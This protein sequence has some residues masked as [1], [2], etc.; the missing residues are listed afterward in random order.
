MEFVQ[1]LQGTE[2]EEFAHKVLY[3]K[4]ASYQ[5]V[6][7]A[8]GGDRGIDGFNGDGVVFQCYGPDPSITIAERAKRHKG[9]LN[10]DLTTFIDRLDAIATLVGAQ[11]ARWVLFVPKCDSAAVLEAAAEHQA[12][13]RSLGRPELHPEFEVRIQ[14]AG[15][16][17]PQVR[18][19]LQG[20]SEL[21]FGLHVG[22]QTVELEVPNEW[23]E[24]LERKVRILGPQQP[25]EFAQMLLD[26][27]ARAT[28]ATRD[29]ED[30]WPE[31]FQIYK[32]VR[33]GQ[34]N[35]VQVASQVS[36]GQDP[37]AFIAE[38]A[39]QA[40]TAAREAIPQLSQPLCDELGWGFIAEMLM[41]CTVDFVDET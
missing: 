20:V 30:G 39:A 18:M 22:T 41:E 27:Y 14:D 13:L 40:A 23:L 25:G 9:K 24:N 26:F 38:R 4:W 11:I 5:A 31:S 32:R 37:R 29:L 3:L 15:Y 1:T 12:S 2:W 7:A 33:I 35:T 21:H 17:E 36:S 6:P 28:S 19:A 34:R 8:H 10:T 16:Y